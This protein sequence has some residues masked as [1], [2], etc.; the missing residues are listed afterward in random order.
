LKKTIFVILALLANYALSQSVLFFYDENSKVPISSVFVKINER[1]IAISDDKGKAT[2][3]NFIN[4]TLVIS[5]ISYE[6]IKILLK[7]NQNVAIY[8]KPKSLNTSPIIVQ[9]KKV[10]T[11]SNYQMIKIDETNNKFYVTN[12]TELFKHQTSFFVKDYGQGMSLK[13]VSSRGM[14]SENTIVLFNEARINDLRTGSFDFNSINL[15]SIDNIDIFY[16]SDDY[17]IYSSVGG[18]IKINTGNFTNKQKYYITT[19]T[20]NDKM[21]S[22]SVGSSI[23]IDKFKFSFNFERTYSPNQYLYEFENTFQNRKNAQF[24]KTFVSTNILYSENNYTNKIY[25]HYNYFNTGIPGAVVSNYDGDNNIENITRAIT[26]I[27]NNNFIINQNLSFFNTIAYNFNEFTILDKDKHLYYPFDKRKSTLEELQST[28]RFFI[29]LNNFTFNISDFILYSKLKDHS[30]INLI[31]NKTPNYNRILN[32]LTFSSNYEYDDDLIMFAKPSINGAI[33]YTYIQENLSKRLNDN[34]YSYKFGIILP[35]EFYNNLRITSNFLRDVREPSYSERFYSTID[36]FS[37][38]DLKNEDYYSYDAAINFKNDNLLPF[39]FTITYFNIKASNKI[40]WVPI[41]RL[42]GLQYPVN[43]GKISSTGYE[44]FFN[45][46]ILPLYSEISFN[47]VYNKSINKNKFSDNDNSYNK[48]L[49]YSPVNK[50]TANYTFD[51]KNVSSCISYNFVGKRYY[52]TDNT[53]RNKLPKYNLV[54]ASIS[55]KFSYE[56]FKFVTGMTVMNIFNEK[57]FIIQ[58]YPMPLR[59]Y[60]IFI[61]MEV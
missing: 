20:T 10:N 43:E 30:N 42:P 16:G 48:L 14:S 46:K 2:I 9:G 13:T 24:N 44:L 15:N 4:D 60:L 22:I 32:K 56:N 11:S 49:V 57:Y 3:S 21:K 17:N 53:P 51:Y 1:V 61:N 39:S 40:V 59:N 7:S 18:I 26:G 47:Y 31:L 5:H 37:D 25:L 12:V 23:P 19:K 35:F 34:F 52:T 50:F 28:N 33:Y 27:I 36:R 29:K 41:S 58:S 54:D 6:K 45:A 38:K 55:Y 8:L